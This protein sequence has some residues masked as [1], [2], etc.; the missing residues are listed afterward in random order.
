MS[1]LTIHFYNETFKSKEYV[2][3][4]NN[5][6]E[7]LQSQLDLIL[8]KYDSLHFVVQR[9]EFEKFSTE[10]PGFS[11]SEKIS[12]EEMLDVESLREIEDVSF[13]STLEKKE[14]DF[15]INKTEEKIYPDKLT[16]V[17]I[18][19][20][21]VKFLTDLYSKKKEKKIQQIRVCFSLEE[22]E[23]IKYGNKEIFIQVV[24]PK[25]QII[26]DKDFFV[27]NNGIKLRY[28]SKIDVLYKQ[29]ALDVCTYVNLEP[30]KTIKGKYIIN[31]YNSF[32]K[33]GSTIFTYN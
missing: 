33:I 27:V 19:V 30:T 21:G 24:N 16:A 12:Q 3:K 31:I 20:R 14:K 7:L 10:E 15:D 8:K 25:N 9:K 22:N 6:N 5:E 29:D 2:E 28:S 17:E 26:S 4:V 13:E 1:C 23:F 32:T 18:N 11:E